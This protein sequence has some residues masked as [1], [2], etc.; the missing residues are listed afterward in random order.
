M[1]FCG[2]FDGHGQWGHHVSKRVKESMPVSLL[3]NWQE[4]LTLASLNLDFQMEMEMDRNLH[5]FD[6]WKQSFL[7]TYA[8][9]DQE[10][11]HSSK[12]DS[13]RSGATASTIVKQVIRRN[14]HI[15]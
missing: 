13:Y 9:I 10:L 7:K 11:K 12:I 15:F 2:I 4:T 6:I 1:I 14:C 8:A 5:W 3:C